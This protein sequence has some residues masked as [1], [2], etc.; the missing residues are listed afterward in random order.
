MKNWIEK[1]FEYLN[2]GEFMENNV[3]T[4]IQWHEAGEATEQTF[5][6]LGLPVKHPQQTGIYIQNGKKI[7]VK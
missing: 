4:A 7:I 6:I 3:N 1:R 5:T 2:N